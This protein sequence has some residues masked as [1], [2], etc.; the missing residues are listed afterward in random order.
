MRLWAFQYLN[1]SWKSGLYIKIRMVVILKSLLTEKQYYP[2]AL[3]FFLLT[4]DS[5]LY[6]NLHN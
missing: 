1:P 6:R 5:I 4:N 2:V 3:N